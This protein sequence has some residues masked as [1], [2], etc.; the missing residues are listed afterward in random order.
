MTKKL[1]AWL[2]ENKVG[3]VR[4]QFRPAFCISLQYAVVH[5]RLIT[6][7]PCSAMQGCLIPAHNL[8]MSLHSLF[9]F[10]DGGTHLTS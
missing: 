9:M 6:G 7:R 10:K 5:Y 3:T 2:S 1:K 4:S 8:R